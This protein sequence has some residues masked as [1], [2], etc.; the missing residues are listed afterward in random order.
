[1]AIRVNYIL[2]TRPLP[3]ELIYEAAVRRVM[4]DTQS[5]IETEPVAVDTGDLANQALTVVFTS[6]NAVAAVRQAGSRW[7]V[8]CVGEETRRK[9]IERF[10]ELDIPA[11]ARS[12]K[13]L[14][15]LMLATCPAREVYF[16][17]GDRRREELPDLLR[18]AGWTVQEIVV[19]KTVL[20]P[21]KITR[22]YAGIA[23]YSPSTVESFF[24]VNESPEPSTILFAIGKTTA[25]AIRERSSNQVIVAARPEREAMIRQMIEYFQHKT[26]Q[27]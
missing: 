21:H 7:T 26:S 25:G 27:H 8:F 2:S 4:I 23:F 17:C 3:A 10:G 19:Y 15:G 14:A 1:M 11:T 12:A 18:Q 16:F 20:T 6:G 22:S 5:F 9:V 24:S 13:E